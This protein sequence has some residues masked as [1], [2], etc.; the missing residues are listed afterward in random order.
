MIN[1]FELLSDDKL[2]EIK[3]IIENEINKRE[4]KNIYINNLINE[5]PCNSHIEFGRL[6]D[7]I[8]HKFNFY[9]LK[10][11]KLSL[12]NSIN[13]FKKDFDKDNIFDIQLNFDGMD[14][15]HQ[16]III[17]NKNT[18]ENITLFIDNNFINHVKSS[19]IKKFNKNLYDKI[20]KFSHKLNTEIKYYSIHYSNLRGYWSIVNYSWTEIT[21]LK[22]NKI[23]KSYKKNYTKLNMVVN[24]N[25]KKKL[26]S[27]F[28]IRKRFKSLNRHLCQKYR[29]EMYN[30]MF[31]IDQ[32]LKLK[33]E[34]VL[35]DFE[36]IKNMEECIIC[37]EKKITPPTKCCKNKLCTDCRNRINKCPMCRNEN[38]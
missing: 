15:K 18:N 2:Q 34:K 38:F 5:Y 32:E 30:Y 23:I 22:D 25:N 35:N 29:L 6:D 33:M 31:N 36:L 10:I 4:L 17:K 21:N 3:N 28:D 12:L 26:I 11:Y 9:D 14:L 8:N 27:H 13:E 16:T 19:K 20:I 7:Y 1:E 24:D 37:Y